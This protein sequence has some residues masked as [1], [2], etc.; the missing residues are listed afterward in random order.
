M[1]SSRGFSLLEALIGVALLGVLAALVLP[2]L[3]E[4][5]RRTD[6]V[7]LARQIAADALRCRIEALTSGRNVGLVFCELERRAYY[8]MVADGDHDGV[9]RVDFIRGVD[10]PIGPKVW[11]EFMSGGTHLGVPGAWKVPDPGGEGTLDG[12]GVRVG[13]SN[14]L[15]FAHTGGATPASVYFNDGASRALAIR[16]WGTVGRVRA[17]VWRQGGGVWRE[18]PL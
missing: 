15:S 7:R 8:V 16:V 12:R 2:D 4:V 11:V 13:A 6:L 17:L 10:R 14:I 18:V 9:S 1:S 5:R 3:S